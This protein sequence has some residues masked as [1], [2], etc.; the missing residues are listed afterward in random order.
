M[1][2]SRLSSRAEFDV[3][4]FAAVG[5]V[6]LD[7]E[8]DV[9]REGE[10]AQVVAVVVADGDVELVD[11]VKR[12]V[13]VEVADVGDVDAELLGDREGD[14]DVEVGLVEVL[15]T[16]AV[17]E[18]LLAVDGVP[19]AGVE[20]DA[21][22]A[23]GRADLGVGLE[24]EAAVFLLVAAEDVVGGDVGPEGEGQ[25]AGVDVRGRGVLADGGEGQGRAEEAQAGEGGDVLH[26][27]TP[28]GG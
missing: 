27:S 11:V 24:D 5:V 22:V 19:D 9:G 23:D 15:G 20:V 21:G 26:S 1:K 4:V 10:V 8:Q 14:A 2:A 7:G 13:R 16:V 3:G 12:A 28:W 6:E 25:G 17:G 18:G